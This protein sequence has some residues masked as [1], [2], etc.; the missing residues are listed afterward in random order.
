[1]EANTETKPTLQV[2]L[3]TA[4]KA[5]R[6]A[7][8]AKTSF[9]KFGEAEQLALIEFLVDFLVNDEEA[10]AEGFDAIRLPM[11]AISNASAYAQKLEKAGI[12][13]RSKKGT[14]GGNA[15]DAFAS[16]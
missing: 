14:V 2:R 10:S 8:L 6:Q 3:V 12:I 7:V 16:V 15:K 11:A 13:A 4:F 1:M 9:T 5:K